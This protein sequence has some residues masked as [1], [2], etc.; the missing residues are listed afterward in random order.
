MP[1]HPG[2]ADEAG[3]GFV[4][5]RTG[6]EA[7]DAIRALRTSTLHGCVIRVQLARATAATRSLQR[8]TNAPSREDVRLALRHEA[9]DAAAEA[10]GVHWSRIGLVSTYGGHQIKEEEL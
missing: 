3:Y 7:Q 10:S 5:L 4:D 2:T 8:E 9:H 1:P 6:A